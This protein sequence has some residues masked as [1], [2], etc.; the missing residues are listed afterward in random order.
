MNSGTR[1]NNGEF[2]ILG[3]DSVEVILRIPVQGIA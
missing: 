3:H 2:S 1:L